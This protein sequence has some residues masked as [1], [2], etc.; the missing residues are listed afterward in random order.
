[1]KIFNKKSEEEKVEEEIISM[2]NRRSFG[3]FFRDYV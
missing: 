1:M 3:N 2:V